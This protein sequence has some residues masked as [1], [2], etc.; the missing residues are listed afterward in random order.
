[1]CIGH[2]SLHWI[3][4]T[5]KNVFD[6]STGKNYGEEEKFESLFMGLCEYKWELSP[7]TSR[8]R[9]KKPVLSHKFPASKEDC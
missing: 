1:M 2:F 4:G 9:N 7:K 8:T 3:L 5:E 6:I